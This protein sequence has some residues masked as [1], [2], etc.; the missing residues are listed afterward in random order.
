MGAEPVSPPIPDDEADIAAIS[1]SET[2]PM[3]LDVVC[4]TAHMGFAALAKVTDDHWVA[5]VVRDEISF[6]LMP[7]SE[8]TLETTLRQ[9][10][11][12]VVVDDVDGDPLFRGHP[13]PLLYGFKSYIAVP[14][15]LPDGRFFGTLCALDRRP[16]RL[17]TPAVMGMFKLFAQ[18]IGFEIEA[19]ERLL[20]HDAEHEPGEA[21]AHDLNN[22]LTVIQ[23]SADLLQRPNL[24]DDRRAR[25]IGRIA[26]AAG[27]AGER[28]TAWLKAARRGSTA[29]RP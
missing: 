12:I 10:R 9:H 16:A 21:I 11:A 26:T 27:R 24:P 7:G 6:G 28:T 3:I 14:V 25:Y 13:T 4:R 15:V 17:D 1:R 22:L 23:S 19:A 2:V 29:E 20:R 18:L 8:L 5:C